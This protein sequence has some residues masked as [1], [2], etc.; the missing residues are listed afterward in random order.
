MAQLVDESF[1]APEGRGSIPV[2]GKLALSTVLKLTKKRPSKPQLFLNKQNMTI[3]KEW[4]IRVHDLNSY[5]CELS[6]NLTGFN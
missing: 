6:Q 2:N 4:E 1:P 3:R 5:R